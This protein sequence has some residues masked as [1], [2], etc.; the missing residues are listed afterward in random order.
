MPPIA[1]PLPLP[2]ADG[3][4]GSRL[5][6]GRRLL[7]TGAAHGFGAALARAAGRCGAEV[8]LLDRDLKA[9]EG[10]Y[11]AIQADGSPEPA[12]YPMDLLGSTPDDHQQL[13][14]RLAES[15]GS[16]Y[17]LVHGA[18]VLGKPAPL[19]HYA[20]QEWLRTLQVNVNGP[21]LLTRSLLPLLRSAAGSRVVFVSDACGRRGKAYMG[22]YGVSKFALEG[23]METLAAET[24]GSDGPVS[25]SLDPGPM[26]TALRR[27]GYPAEGPV[28][29]PAPEQVALASL[30]LLD[31]GGTPVNGGRY[32]YGPTSD[33]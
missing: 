32:R 11:D 24:E 25:M 16:L 31:P 15:F 17:A 8:I 30:G 26:A 28:E 13:A 12:L 6:A 10:V 23:L 1:D 27:Q 3:A 18:A 20:P 5:L 9:L 7:I 4:A 21:F 22:G 29:H 14:A 33:E 19:E 2:A